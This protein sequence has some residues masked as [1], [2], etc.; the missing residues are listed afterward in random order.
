MIE[1]ASGFTGKKQQKWREI[2][3]QQYM[4]L[5]M[6]KEA[7]VMVRNLTQEAPTIP[8]W[9]KG[10]A[11]IQLQQNNYKK[12]LAAMTI[13]SYLTP[14]AQDE[15]KLLADLYMQQRIPRKAV[16]YY[17]KYAQKKIDSQTALNLARSYLDLGRPKLALEKLNT[18]A[19]QLK[20]QEIEMTRGEI[21]YSTKQYA[22]AAVAFKHATTMSEKKK[23]RGFLMAGYSYWQ[24]GD[25]RNAEI[26]FKKTLRLKQNLTKEAHNALEQLVPYSKITVQKK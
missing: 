24:L 4:S 11:H 19:K 20:N 18:F 15:E 3:L 5:N 10:L 26:A 2:L 7:L 12:A 14:L 6:H 8:I 22:K 13:Y 9:W 23:A 25:Y 16:I 17:E 21:L 1:L